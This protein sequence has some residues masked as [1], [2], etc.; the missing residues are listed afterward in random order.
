MILLCIIWFIPLVFSGGF[1]DDILR[2]ERLLNTI[3]PNRSKV[4][5]SLYGVFVPDSKSNC[6]NTLNTS[7]KVPCVQCAGLKHCEV[8]NLLMIQEE[9]YPDNKEFLGS[10]L[11][12]E[13]LAQRMQNEIFGEGKT[14]RDTSECREIVMQYLCLFWASDNSMYTNCCVFQEDTSDADPKKHLIAPRPPC[15][16]FCT[17]VA[18]ICAN[19]INFMQICLD[20]KCPPLEVDCTPDPTL[21]QVVL[22]ANVGCDIVY[23]KDPYARKPKNAARAS[24]S[25]SFLVVFLMVVATL[26]TMI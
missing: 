18:E 5:R 20:I 19:D 2:K 26:F 15:R 13:E 1:Y 22:D 3:F 9:Y 23:V 14:F 8:L 7:I 16:S 12:I 17:Q 6:P 4:K 10:C 21:D 24:T 11:I 25:R